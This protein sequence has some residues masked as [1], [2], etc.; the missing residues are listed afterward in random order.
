MGSV[1]LVELWLLIGMYRLTNIWVT[2]AIV[3]GTAA[4]GSFL[5]RRQGL[6]TLRKFQEESARGEI[7][8]DRIV[9]G[10]ILL[11]GGLL[12]V[13]PGILTDLTGLALM[14][15]G[16]R[17]LL[18]GFLKRRLAGKIVTTVV[19]PTPPRQSN[20]SGESGLD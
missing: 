5:L 18:R 13:T 12:L 1:T 10:L 19:S 7:P 14:I 16:N 4:L 9:D 17:R 8:T 20:E 3:I 6:R 15:P 2:I 11:A